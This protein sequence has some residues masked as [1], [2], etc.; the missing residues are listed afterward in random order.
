VADTPVRDQKAQEIRSRIAAAALELFV[1]QGYAETTIDQ[2]AHAA[3]VGRRTVFRHFTSKEAMLF[4][5][6]AVRRH[7]ALHRLQER[8]LSEPALVSLYTVLR[9]LCEQGYDR[10]LLSQI[11]AVLAIEPR[12]ATEQLSIGVRA[13]EDS[14]IA[15]LQSRLSNRHSDV[16]IQ[17][18][19]EMAEGW[20]ITA[21]RVFFKK[22]ER[23]LV[24]YFDEVVA[25]CVQASAQ[26][27]AG[28]SPQRSA[29]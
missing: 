20:F 14:L 27:L 25:G 26:D 22:G 24:E 16:E 17:A 4:D 29:P 6:L 7:F 15:T 28:A 8:P 5:H 10:Q 2:I 9:E 11:R 21:V 18:L 13:F 23:S 1:N 19:T 12:F 3:G